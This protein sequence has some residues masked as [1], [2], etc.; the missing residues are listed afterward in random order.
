MYKL[1]LEQ[2]KIPPLKIGLD[3]IPKFVEWRTPGEK[4]LNPV[5]TKLLDFPAMQRYTNFGM[6]SSNDANLNYV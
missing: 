3:T 5:Q 6:V 2:D 1:I 4:V